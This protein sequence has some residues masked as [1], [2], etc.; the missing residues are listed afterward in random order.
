MIHLLLVQSRYPRLQAGAL[1]FL[2]CFTVGFIVEALREVWLEPL[3]GEPRALALELIILLV[4]SAAAA[5]STIREARP[6]MSSFDRVVV[7][8]VALALLVGAQELLARIFLGASV[9]DGWSMLS[10]EAQVILA[11]LM[12]S[13]TAMPLLAVRPSQP[14]PP[15]VRE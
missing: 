11:L 12:V 15:A 4:V 1:Y 10:S 2:V 13:F 7:G 5:N 8:L 6:T 3:I 14:P 9:V